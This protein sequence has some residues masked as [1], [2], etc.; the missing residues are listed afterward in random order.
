MATNDDCVSRR[1]FLKTAV[2]VGVGAAESLVPRSAYAA[3]APSLPAPEYRNRTEGMDYRRFGKT[4][5]MLSTLGVGGAI[6]PNEDMYLRFLDAG[7]NYVQWYGDAALPRVLKK[8]PDRL[9]VIAK[10]KPSTLSSKQ[11]LGKHVD[12]ILKRLSVDSLDI[13]DVNAP[14]SLMP[15]HLAET[16]AELKEAGRLKALTRGGHRMADE[17]MA[18]ILPTFAKVYDGTIGG[19]SFAEQ[20]TVP[21]NLARKLNVGLIAFKPH[22]V[23]FTP[24]LLQ[25]AKAQ[26]IDTQQASVRWILAQPG[27]VSMIRAMRDATQLE[28]N[29]VAVRKM[30]SEEEDRFMGEAGAQLAATTCQLCEI[31]SAACPNNVRPCDMQRTRLYAEVFEDLP[32]ASTEYKR[33]NLAERAA[34]CLDCGV[35]EEACPRHLPIRETI[36][37]TAEMLG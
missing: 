12:S 16:V 30:L 5:M 29:L 13:L 7:I 24:E 23:K 22:K 19:Y 21:L 33:L 11:Q 32:R 35:C 34:A 8:H 1:S 25:K 36:R 31:C 4:G 10:G 27:F 37:M 6:K 28:S 15:E 18:D 20:G 14:Y 9:F 3:E 26:G 17:G 2:G